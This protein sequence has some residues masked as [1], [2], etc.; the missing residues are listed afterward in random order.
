MALT[1]MYRSKEFDSTNNDWYW[2]KYEPNGRVSEMADM[3]V[4]G[5]V[6]MCIECHGGAG[7]DDFVFAND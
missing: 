3:P 2:V 6:G 7:G 1:V 5:R 4:A